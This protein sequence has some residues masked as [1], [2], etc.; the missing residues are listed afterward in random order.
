MSKVISEAN[1]KLKPRQLLQNPTGKR[2]INFMV[3]ESGVLFPTN[4][5]YSP[6]K[7]TWRGKV[8]NDLKAA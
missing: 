4:L 1:T 6:R 2:K 7:I 8:G 5:P 3:N